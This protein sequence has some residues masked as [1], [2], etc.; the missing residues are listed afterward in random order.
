M[1]SL[2]LHNVDIVMYAIL[3]PLLNPRFR[4]GVK[5]YVFAILPKNTDDQGAPAAWFVCSSVSA[6]VDCCF[7]VK[8]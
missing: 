4:K 5:Y 1:W 2:F 6:A 8:V 7:R 3:S